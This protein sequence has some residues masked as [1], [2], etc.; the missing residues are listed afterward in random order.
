M[1][2]VIAN[3]DKELK[4][5]QKY[6]KFCLYNWVISIYHYSIIVFSAAGSFYF[7]TISGLS[8]YLLPF[9]SIGSKILMLL[10]LYS[11]ITSIQ[12]GLL[13]FLRKT[14]YVSTASL[15]ELLVIFVS[16]TLL[17][18]IHSAWNCNATLSLNFGRLSGI[19]FLFNYIR[20][21]K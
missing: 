13:I 19:F 14:Y 10:P 21:I 15:I 7:H 8:D 11:A 5:S 4:K 16:L 9:A 2:L 6:P 12:R 20:K 17:I 3:L 1:E 18:N